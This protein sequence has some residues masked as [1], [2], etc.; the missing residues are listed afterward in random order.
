MTSGSKLSKASSGE[1]TV[2]KPLDLGHRCQYLLTGLP[3][4]RSRYA[5]RS[6]QRAGFGD[7]RS[8]RGLGGALVA[9]AA[10]KEADLLRLSA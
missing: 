5:M 2:A 7:W 3:L 8:I 4:D 10:Q 9:V 6:A 1:A